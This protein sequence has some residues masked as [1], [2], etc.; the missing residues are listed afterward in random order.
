MTLHQ[1]AAEIS[2]RACTGPPKMLDMA[3]SDASRGLLGIHSLRSA[4]LP[5]TRKAGLIRPDSAVFRFGTPEEG[6]AEQFRALLMAVFFGI[7]MSTLRQWSAEPPASY[8]RWYARRPERLPSILGVRMNTSWWGPA[9]RRYVCRLSGHYGVTVPYSK[10]SESGCVLS[11]DLLREHIDVTLDDVA[12]AEERLVAG[13]RWDGIWDDEPFYRK[14]IGRDD[15]DP[16]PTHGG[17]GAV[18]AV[19]DGAR[20]CDAV[21]RLPLLCAEIAAQLATRMPEQWRELS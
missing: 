4:R 5:V 18:R 10:V 2:G 21:L 14:I 3:T 11:T 19:A 12:A 17:C 7:S 8:A 20:H 6:S 9:G 16:G 15:A 13:W 1:L